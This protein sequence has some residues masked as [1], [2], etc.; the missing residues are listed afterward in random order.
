MKFLNPLLACGL[1]AATISSPA[2]AQ[3]I[4]SATSTLS[5]ATLINFEGLAEG[6]LVGSGT[7]SGVTFSQ[8]DGG[9]PQIDNS[10]FLFGY[11]PSSG[12]GVLTGST[13]GGAPFP[14]VAGLTVTF[15]SGQSSVEAFL[16]DTSA[17]G[18]YNILAYG[19][20][21]VLLDSFNASGTNRY[22]G[23]SGL[24]ADIYSVQFGPSS[25]FGD[26]FAIDDVRFVAATGAVPEPGTWAMMLLG[27]GGMGV[28]LRRRRSL[29]GTAQLA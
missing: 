21:G 27:F 20:G 10:P 24:G 4:D 28:A 14:T 2:Q 13:E 8:P 1:F 12:T 15:S 11:G 29:T 18:T 3:R 16:S 22:V 17:L 19:F 23:F 9:R 5:G 6:T 26:A 25:A 7:Y